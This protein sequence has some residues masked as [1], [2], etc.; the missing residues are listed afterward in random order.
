MIDNPAAS[1][2]K[3]DRFGQYT[4]IPGSIAIFTQMLGLKAWVF[5]ENAK[6]ARGPFATDD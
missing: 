1:L 3:H 5:I 2:G 6:S 4:D